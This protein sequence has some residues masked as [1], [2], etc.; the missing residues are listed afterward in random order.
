ME[1]FE[2]D[3][4]D[5]QLNDK[6]A[7][8]TKTYNIRCRLCRKQLFISDR[9]KFSHSGSSDGCGNCIF[10]DEDFIPDWIQSEIENSSWTKG[11]LKCPRAQCTARVGGF[12]FIQGLL[13]G[14]GKLTIPA[15]WIQDGKVDVRIISNSNCISTAK[16][17]LKESHQ[18]CSGDSSSATGGVVNSNDALSKPEA[19]L[20]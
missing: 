5:I 10:L 20:H 1:N 15:I 8:E 3:C 12:D 2:K 19:S 14:C 18:S 7:L 13:C 6:L 16:P 9:V 17:N 4:H 11:R